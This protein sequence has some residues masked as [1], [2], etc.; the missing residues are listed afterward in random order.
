MCVSA[1]RSCDARV[2]LNL[3]GQ[4]V[5]GRDSLKILGVTLDKDCS[6][7]SHVN[8]LSKKLRKKTWALSKLRKKGMS[9]DDLIQAYKTLI[10]PTEEY[11]SPVWHS[12]ITVDESEFLE[13]Q[14]TQ[15]LGNI[16]G[17]ELSARRMRLKS[18]L[19]RH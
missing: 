15:A 4:T 18:D 9:E 17:T 12:L 13:R 1:A 5:T 2:K 6:F 8:I 10:R 19:E 7:T 3:N 16:Y 14:Q 11:A